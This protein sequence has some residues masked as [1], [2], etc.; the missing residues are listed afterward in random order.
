MNIGI[1]WVNTSYIDGGANPGGKGNASTQGTIDYNKCRDTY[2]VGV[3]G[4]VTRQRYCRSRRVRV[5][6]GA[7]SVNIH[8]P[9]GSYVV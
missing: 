4:A 3:T 7:D 5:A 2:W 8:L 9:R 1:E 6:E